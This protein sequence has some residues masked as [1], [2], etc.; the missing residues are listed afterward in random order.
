LITNIPFYP[1]VGNHEVDSGAVKPEEFETRYGNFHKYFA[2]PHYYS[3]DYGC[4]HFCVLDCPSMMKAIHRSDRDRYIP[5]LIDDFEKSEQYRF[6]EKD[7]ASSRATWKFVVFH[8]PP[9]T[10][11]IFGHNELKVLCPLFEKYGVDIVFNS[12]A[13]VYERSHPIKEDRISKN[14]V[15]YILVGGYD[16]ISRWFRNKQNG[17]AAKIAGRPGYVHVSLTPYALE[18]QAIDYEGKMFDMLT[19]EKGICE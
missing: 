18:L 5:E 13:I 8:Y 16:D 6:L 17:F 14:G 12:H 3:F 9:Y 7:L 2:F 15:R 4:A 1:C 19:L 11:A 10:S